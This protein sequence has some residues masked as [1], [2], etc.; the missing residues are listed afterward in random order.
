[1]YGA[2]AYVH[3]LDEKLRPRGCKMLARAMVGKLCRY[4]G[5]SGKVYRIRLDNSGR[6]VR[7]RDTRFIENPIDIEEDY[8]PD[9]PIYEVTFEDTYYEGEFFRSTVY[10]DHDVV[11]PK[12]QQPKVQFGKEAPARKADLPTPETT[13]ELHYDLPLNHSDRGESSDELQS[14][15]ENE[16]EVQQDSVLTANNNGLVRR[17]FR[18]ARPPGY[19]KTLNTQGK[20]IA[21]KL[22]SGLFVDIDQVEQEDT[23]IILLALDNKD[24]LAP[25]MDG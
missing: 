10:L 12:N 20:E 6:I 4:K 14:S 7:A 11:Y 2:K 19:Y 25:K 24:L 21:E 17:S 9:N 15:D 16:N 5:Q 22:I 3:I 18:N 8:N 1:M 23:E 13:P